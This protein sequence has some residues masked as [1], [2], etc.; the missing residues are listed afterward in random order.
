MKKKE[1]TRWR[2]APTIWSA[3]ICRLL[4]AT[5]PVRGSVGREE[6]RVVDAP[7]F[8]PPFLFM[9]DALAGVPQGDPPGSFS[10]PQ[11]GLHPRQ[12]LQEQGKL[13]PWM[14]SPVSCPKGSIF[15]HAHIWSVC[16]ILNP[17]TP[18]NPCSGKNHLKLVSGGVSM[19]LS[20][21]RHKRFMY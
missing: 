7:T 15:L 19:A 5:Q 1:R 4:R 21:R 10:C 6:T 2:F 13:W 9:I 14:P 8:L 16:F 3:G 17:I 20:S 11:D 18:G 12:V